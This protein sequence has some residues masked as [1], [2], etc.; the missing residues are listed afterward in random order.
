MVQTSQDKRTQ[1]NHAFFLFHVPLYRRCPFTAYIDDY[2]YY[3]EI[4]MKGT[5]DESRFVLIP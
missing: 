3:I 2:V 1:A 4:D 5:T